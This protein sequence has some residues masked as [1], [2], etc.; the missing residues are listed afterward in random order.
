M[1]GKLIWQQGSNKP[2]N[3]TNLSYISQWWS[4]LANKDVTLAQRMIPQTGELDQLNW[5]TQRFDEVF[6]IQNPE[7][8]GITLY[9]RKPNSTQERNTTPYQLMLD[10][11]RQQLYIFPQS[12]Q[13][14]VMRV[15]LPQ[16][17]YETIEI[18]NPQIE[19]NLSG[20][21]HILTLRDSLQKL[22]VK[23]TMS[24][25]NLSQLKEQIP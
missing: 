18:N 17:I 4:S 3:S 16:I 1:H 11:R 21:N 7:I 22:E 6:E 25:D 24:G 5:E 14:L 20:E 19:Y 15:A 12:Q 8:R 2:D 9:W 10:T 13:Q 23:L